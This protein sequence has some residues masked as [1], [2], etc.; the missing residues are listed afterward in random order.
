VVIHHFSGG[1]VL[2]LPQ[3]GENCGTLAEVLL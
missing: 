2:R 3:K 1:M